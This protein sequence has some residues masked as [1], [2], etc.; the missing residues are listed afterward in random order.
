MS[1]TEFF[2]IYALLFY[3]G[4]CACV[5]II[6][7]IDQSVCKKKYIYIEGS[8]ARA[9]GRLKNGVLLR[10]DG[11]SLRSACAA[12]CSGLLSYPLAPGGWVRDSS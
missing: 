5:P 3:F 8:S 10:K 9:T 4:Q 11:V 7:F 6:V 1:L 2:V 12:T